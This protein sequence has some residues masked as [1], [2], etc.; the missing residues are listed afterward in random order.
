MCS[1]QV[2]GKQSTPGLSPCLSLC[3]SL[4]GARTHCYS[5][6]IPAKTTN[7]ALK[8]LERSVSWDAGQI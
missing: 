8:L 7:L 6:A 2:V 3:V 5:L 1:C 4:M